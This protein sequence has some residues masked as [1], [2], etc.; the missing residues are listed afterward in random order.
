MDPLQETMADAALLE[1]VKAI[2]SGDDRFD[3]TIICTT[4]DHQAAYWMDRLA[5]GLL[6]GT[7]VLAVSEDWCVQCC[8]LLR[9]VWTHIQKKSRVS[10][11]YFA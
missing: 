9:E 4:D 5:S 2:N 10:T 8:G 6:Q 3:V 1:A 11:G 7:K